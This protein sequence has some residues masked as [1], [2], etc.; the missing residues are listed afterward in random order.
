MRTTGKNIYLIAD[1]IKFCY[2]DEGPENAPVIIFIHG[3]PFNKNMWEKQSEAL[4][5]KYRVVAID[6]RGHGNS[7]AGKE[8]FSIN[9]F[10]EDLIHIMDLLQISRAV[11]CGLSMGGYISLNALERFPNYFSA[12]I[13]CDTQCIA[14]TSEVKEKR[15]KTIHFIK[16]NGLEKYADESLKNLFADGSFSTKKEEIAFIR[17]TILKTSADSVCN[18]LRALADRSETCATLKDIKIPVLILVGREDKITPPSAAQLMHEKIEDSQMHIIEQAGHVSNM[19]NPGDFNKYLKNFLDKIF[20]EY[21]P[22]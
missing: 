15:K 5:N 2:C 7:D 8:D 21:F 22:G 17:E 20:S 6:L 12:L 16:E 13:L 10:A 3:F 1:H 18:T 4:K 9:L 19:E 11:L 14:D